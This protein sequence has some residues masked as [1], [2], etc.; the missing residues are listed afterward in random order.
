MAYCDKDGD[1]CSMYV[2]RNLKEIS[3]ENAIENL[4]I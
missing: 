3:K 4:I 2:V 1:L